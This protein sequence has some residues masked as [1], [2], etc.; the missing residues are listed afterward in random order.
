MGLKRLQILVDS[1]YWCPR[2][3]GS[4]T[5]GL[6]DP[7]TLRE[8][9]TAKWGTGSTRSQID[10]CMSITPTAEA[11]ADRSTRGDTLSKKP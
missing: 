7:S 6:E 8:V 2:V 10:P 5:G 11:E 1:P 3:L 9:G 4:E